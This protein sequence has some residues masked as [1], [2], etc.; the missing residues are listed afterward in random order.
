MNWSEVF[1]TR[2]GERVTLDLTDP[3]ELGRYLAMVDDASVA[4][5]HVDDVRV[6]TI[7]LIHGCGLPGPDRPPL[8]FETMIFGGPHT[9]WCR[10]YATEDDARSGH[11]AVVDALRNGR[12]PEAAP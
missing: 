4:V 9:M 11:A 12:Y 2:A 3:E 6:S 10:R 7:H 1:Y 8:I 5:D